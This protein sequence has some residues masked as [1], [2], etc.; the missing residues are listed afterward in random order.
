MKELENITERDAFIDAYTALKTLRADV[1][2]SEQDYARF[3]DAVQDIYQK[4]LES[5]IGGPDMEFLL[6]YI[7]KIFC[8][9]A[10]F[11]ALMLSNSSS[12][13]VR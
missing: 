12:T 11:S 7:E 6:D 13:R 4:A 2:K 1:E 8:E 5:S 9:R 10:G 3:D